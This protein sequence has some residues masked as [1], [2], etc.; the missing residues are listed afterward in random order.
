MWLLMKET[1]LA[2]IEDR[3]ASM[4]ASLAY[5]TLFSMAPLL[6]I[7]LSVAGLVFGQEAARGEIFGQLRGLIGDNGAMVIQDLLDH[8]HRPGRGVSSMVIGVGI[9]LIGAT[10]VFTELKADLDLIWKTPKSPRSGLW[11]LITVRIMAV[12]L[13]L[14]FGFLL[15]IS[16]VLS[17][18][19]TGLGSHVWGR[20]PYLLEV[21]NFLSFTF[22]ATLL[23]ALIYR[24]VPDARTPWPDVWAGA[25][26]T[27]L[28]FA[29]G[30]ALIGLYIGT[31][32]VASAFGAAGGLVALLVWVYYSAMI[33]L[34]GAEFTKSWA[35]RRLLPGPVPQVK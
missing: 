27:S 3:A 11:S 20:I 30:K 14:A 15:V 4:G 24:F 34:F 19:L 6:L 21:L 13:I 23:F 8:V 2:W 16:L 10:S 32:A 22:L 26:V 33:F 9:L 29:A 18:A 25:M 31:S 17:A 7:A 12:G 5:Y 35:R 1:V 28:L